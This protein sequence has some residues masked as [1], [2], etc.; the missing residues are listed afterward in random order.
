[1]K[2]RHP[3]QAYGAVSWASIRVPL[4]GRFDQG[5]LRGKE[6]AEGLASVPPSDSAKAARQVRA[7]ARQSEEYASTA[8]RCLDSCCHAGSAGEG[9]WSKLVSRANA[10]ETCQTQRQLTGGLGVG[11]GQGADQNLR[12]AHKIMGARSERGESASLS[13]DE[14]SLTPSGLRAFAEIGMKDDYTS[15][16]HHIAGRMNGGEQSAVPSEAVRTDLRSE[17]VRESQPS[18]R[19]IKEGSRALNHPAHPEKTS[20]IS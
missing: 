20:G 13:Q 4:V 2:Q 18:S 9:C 15:E 7:T 10:T 11:V 17:Y 3:G 1:M 19:K 6:T 16:D 5:K 8:R 14:A 12:A